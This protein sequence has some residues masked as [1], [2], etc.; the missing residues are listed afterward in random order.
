MILR[1]CLQWSFELFREA[2]EEKNLEYRLLLTTSSRARV[3]GD[4]TRLRQV[5]ANLMSNAVKFT[6]PG[7]D[8]DG[9][10][11]GRDGGSATA[12]TYPDLGSRIRAS[13]SPKTES[14]VSFNRSAR[15]TLRRPGVMEA[16]AWGSQSPNVWWK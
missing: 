4:A 7:L 6:T 14:T 3:S 1:A 12:G 5:T 15:S 10:A 11:T 13:E 2:A 9:G 16:R 8:R